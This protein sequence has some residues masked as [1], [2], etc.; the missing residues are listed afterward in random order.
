[1]CLN[2]EDLF[3]GNQARGNTASGE[4]SDLVRGTY[5]GIHYLRSPESY[6]AS[7]LYADWRVRQYPLVYNETNLDIPGPVQV[8]VY[9]EGDCRNDSRP[10]YAYSCRR[11]YE[12]PSVDWSAK[13]ISLQPHDEDAGNCLNIA[14]NG[15]PEEVYETPGSENLGEDDADD[16]GAGGRSHT[17]ICA[18]TAAIAMAFAVAVVL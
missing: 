1:M 2:L 4:D 3:A 15:D 17:G 11:S 7:R 10:Y 16:N 12:G 5:R 9:G 18:T 6:N 8:N 13:S 14:K